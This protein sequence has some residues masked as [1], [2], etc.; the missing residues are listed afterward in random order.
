V[1]IRV[2]DVN[3]LRDPMVCRSEL[4]SE[5]AEALPS[6]LEIVPVDAE[7][8]VMQ[9]ASRGLVYSGRIGPGRD[10]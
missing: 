9:G 1:A 2:G 8:D 7:S 3:R 5:V 4:D 6:R 10:K